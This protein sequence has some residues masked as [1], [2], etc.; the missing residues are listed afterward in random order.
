MTQEY[1]R[2]LVIGAQ[3]AL[4]AS[5]A[6]GLSLAIARAFNL[7]DPILALIAAVIVTDRKA[8]E[9]RRLGIRRVLSTAIGAVCGVALSYV[10]GHS[11]W[12]ATIA[13]FVAMVAA[14]A[15][16]QLSDP[17]LAAYLCA[18]ILTNHSDQPIQYA[19]SRFA[20]TLIGIVVAWTI[21]LIPK[22]I[23][24]DDELDGSAKP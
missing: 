13:M 5:V 14:T 22:L 16:T 3:V 10:L 6:A 24:L 21:S 11:A 8:T 19:Y 7:S 18:L 12:E 15:I 20:E 23:H 17:K 1:F 2:H 9:T 4:R